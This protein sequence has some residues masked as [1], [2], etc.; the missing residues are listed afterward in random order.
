MEE[1]KNKGDNNNLIIGGVVSVIIFVIYLIYS[2]Y[3]TDRMMDRIEND[4]EKIMRDTERQMD[5]I[6]RD[7][8]Y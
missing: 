8:N 5:D 3:E 7:Y 1:N 2:S 6:M 4:T